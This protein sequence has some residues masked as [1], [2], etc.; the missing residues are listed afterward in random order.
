MSILFFIVLVA[1]NAAL[2]LLKY[3]LERKCDASVA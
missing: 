1:L 3:Y 2:L